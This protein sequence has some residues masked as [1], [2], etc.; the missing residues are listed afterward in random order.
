MLRRNFLG[1]FQELVLS[2]GCAAD[3]VF[4]RFSPKVLDQFGANVCLERGPVKVLLAAI[5]DDG[6]E[7]WSPDGCKSIVDITIAIII[8]ISIVT[9]AITTA[10]GV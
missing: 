9:I 3:G 7:G 1:D 8:T 2:E 6:V 10:H 4:Q 5:N